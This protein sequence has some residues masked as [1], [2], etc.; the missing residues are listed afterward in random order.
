MT[1]PRFLVLCAALLASALVPAAA[2]A[3]FPG[4]NGPIAF[5]DVRDECCLFTIAPSGGAA[6]YIAGT[7]ASIDPAISPDGRSVAFSSGRDLWIAGVDGSGAR[8]VTSGGNNDQHAAWS[9]DGKQLVFTRAAEDDLFVVGT[10]GSGLRNLTGDGG[11]AQEYEPSWSPDGT[12]I[13]FARGTSAGQGSIYVI[14]AGGGGSTNITPEDPTPPTCDPDFFRASKEP[15]W[16]PDGTRIAFTGPSLCPGGS[17]P[18]NY[19]TDIWLMAPNG[20][21]KTN[22]TNNDGPSEAEPHWSPDGAEIAFTSDAEEREGNSDLMAM[23]ADGSAMRKIVDREIKGE[24]IDWGPAPPARV[25]PVRLTAKSKALSGRRVRTTGKLVL[26]AGTATC[27][28]RVRVTVRKGS[29]KAGSRTVK[30]TAGC[31]YSARVRTKRARG[32]VKVSAA[33]LGTPAVAPKKA[34]SR[35][36]R[37]R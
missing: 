33:F 34:R 36:I 32:K 14:P 6:S 13:A 11:T 30:L 5:E 18:K 25:V 22:I 15:S 29:R 26:P 37:L 1:P 31:R 3:S 24:D 28:G 16:S 19:G 4:A 7:A 23:N 20:G 2:Q 27:S 12:T 35:S 21:G 10:D 17:G 8:A 9:P